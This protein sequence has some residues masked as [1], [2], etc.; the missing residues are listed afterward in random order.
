MY[1]AGEVPDLALGLDRARAV[2][3]SGA[4]LDKLHDLARR[5]SELGADA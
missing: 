3:Q 2:L 1:V 5:T 4:A